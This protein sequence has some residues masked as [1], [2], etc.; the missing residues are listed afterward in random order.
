MMATVWVAIE[1]RARLLPATPI[2]IWHTKLHLIHLRLAG[3]KDGRQIAC[4]TTR[5]PF[6]SSVRIR[7]AS[8]SNDVPK[9]TMCHHVVKNDR[10][11]CVPILGHS[12][13]LMM[14]AG[15]EDVGR[16]A[17][18]TRHPIGLPTIQPARRGNVALI[19]RPSSRRTT[20]AERPL[21]SAIKP[22][23]CGQS[24]QGFAMLRTLHKSFRRLPAGFASRI[25]R[26]TRV[27]FRRTRWFRARQ[28][29]G[30]PYPPRYVAG[31]SKRHPCPRRPDPSR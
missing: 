28:A 18:R 6:F 19:S 22:S 26:D 27:H 21:T 1:R 20:I 17:M 8:I 14:N 29:S 11:S 9:P 2:F 16:K 7:T 13:F 12:Y 4:P 23:A 24:S 31:T 15:F 25:G 3:C 5:V 30:F 10:V